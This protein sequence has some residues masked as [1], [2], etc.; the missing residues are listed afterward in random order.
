MYKVVLDPDTQSIDNRI[1]RIYLLYK[2]QPRL[3]S[4]SAIEASGPGDGE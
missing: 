2:Y 4:S 3:E 1:D